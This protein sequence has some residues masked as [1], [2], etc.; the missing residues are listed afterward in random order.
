MQILQHMYQCVYRLGAHSSHRGGQERLT[1]LDLSVLPSG[2]L[3]SP[4]L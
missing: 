2:R 3:K 4:L 1:D